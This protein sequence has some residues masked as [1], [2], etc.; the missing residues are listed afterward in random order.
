MDDG[1][2]LDLR[3]GLDHRLNILEC[4]TSPVGHDLK[5]FAI[6]QRGRQFVAFVSS[7]QLLPI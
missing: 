3:R 4:R 5:R 2:H 7:D 6:L 1:V